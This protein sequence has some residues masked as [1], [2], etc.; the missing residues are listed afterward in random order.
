[1]L[2]YKLDSIGFLYGSENFI[3]ESHKVTSGG[4]ASGITR[5]Y[6]DDGSLKIIAASGNGN[7]ASIGFAKNSND[8]VGAKLTVGDTYTLSC[9]IKVE[10]GTTLPTIFINSGNGYKRL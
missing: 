7:Y 5:T 10:S 9:E 1:V 6:M 2:H 8:N 4:N 3:L